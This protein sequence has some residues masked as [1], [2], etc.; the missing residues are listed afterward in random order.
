MQVRFHAIW[1]EITPEL[2]KALLP[3]IGNDDFPAML[4]AEQAESIKQLCGLD[5]QA[6]ALALLPLAAAYSLAPVSHFYVGAIARGESGNLYFGANMEFVGVPLQQTIHAEQSAI[7]HAW[8][9]GEK[10]LV[11]ITVNY[12][13]CGHCR[14][15]M[16]EL[17]SGTQ[18]EVCLPN[19]SSLTLADYLPEA[20][21]PH[22]LADTPLL[23]DEVNHGHQLATSD[24]LVQAALDAANRSHAPYSQSH[25]GIALQDEQGKIYTGRYAENAAFNPSLPPLQAALIFMNMAGG[26]FKSIKRAV[27]V[28]GENSHLSQ[29]NATECTLA[30]L[31]C[32]KAERYTF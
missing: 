28:E 4:T 10:K 32:T 26:N 15:F 6:L 19:H 20:F 8:L 1:S 30:A 13:P 22:D 3:Y 27:L 12:S 25:A 24:E 16:N 14:Q 17:N 2:Q 11:T 23:L 9:R 29:W 18:L 31:G 21:G 7:T 5:D